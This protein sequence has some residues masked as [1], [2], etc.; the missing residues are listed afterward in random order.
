MKLRGKN[1]H[2]LEET[3]LQFHFRNF[4]HDKYVNKALC[5][6]ALLLCR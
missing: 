5:E 3:V 4:S 1:I 6:R 2:A